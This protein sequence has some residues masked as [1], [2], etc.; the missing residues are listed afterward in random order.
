MKTAQPGVM[1]EGVRARRRSAPMAEPMR[2][3]VLLVM[4]AMS[5]SS[6]AG[7]G[8]YRVRDDAV[9]YFR[10]D[11]SR[12][13]M[14]QTS[15]PLRIP[16]AYVEIDEQGAFHYQDRDQVQRALALVAEGTRPKY[17]VVFVHGWFHSA[18]KDDANV[19]AFKR[20]LNYLQCIDDNAGE[21]VVGI[22][23]GWRGES[24]TLPVLRFAT[25][26]DR[27]NTS[28]EI[29]R[30]SLVE[31]LMRLE[32]TVKPN[33]ASLN[34]LMVIGHSFGAS[35]VFNSIGQ[36]LLARFLLDA[37]K[38][39][40]V[41][42][43]PSHAQ[44]KPGLVS[45]YG[46]LVVLVNPAIEATRIVP[47]FTALN[48]YTA[49]SP[50]LLSPAQPPRLVILSSQGDSA[51][52]R[53][54]PI[55]RAVATTLESYQNAQ[56]R[57][58]YGQEIE[59][60]ER[61]LDWQTMGNVEGL[62]THEPLRK[63]S[64]APWDGTC[65]PAQPEWLKAAIEARKGEQRRMGERET[66]A[67]WSTVFDGTSIGLKHRGVTTP[68]NPLWLMAVGTELIPNHS[69]ITE[70]DI[71]CFFNTILGDPKVTNPE[72]QRHLDRLRRSK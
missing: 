69:G 60:R 46:D 2:P 17:V 34:K 66:G 39:A 64:T 72:G 27:K 58:P 62:L 63:K 52:R 37:E 3:F 41:E 42:P 51:T 23:I 1:P 59:L 7:Q 70:S 12:C 24:W 19:A 50:D 18:A 71:I 28:E 68:S 55:A 33:P 56:V 21:E 11:T 65:P 61:Y 38:L 30:G 32:A 26:W 31:F 9:E 57:T 54:F 10:A 8:P 43:R 14:L 22:Y 44:T 16:I 40:S 47:F 48:D 53:T 45:G 20:A 35:V 25:F 13:P 6:C 15:S 4:F 49:K 29:G 36:I 5:L 67:G